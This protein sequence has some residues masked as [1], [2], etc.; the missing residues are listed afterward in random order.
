MISL[1]IFELESSLIQLVSTLIN[2]LNSTMA[3]G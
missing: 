1:I 3:N 2:V